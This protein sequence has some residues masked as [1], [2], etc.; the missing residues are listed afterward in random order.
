MKIQI[1][2]PLW[3]RLTQ[4]VVEKRPLNGCQSVISPG[5]EP[6]ETNGTDITKDVETRETRHCVLTECNLFRVI[7][8]W[9]TLY[10]CSLS[11]I[12]WFRF[13][14]LINC[15]YTICCSWQAA[16]RVHWDYLSCRHATTSPAVI[17]RL[18][19]TRALQPV[20]TCR[21][22]PYLHKPAII[23]MTSFSLWRHLRVS[24]LRLSQFPR[25]HYDVIRY[26]AGHAHRYGRTDTLPRLI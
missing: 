23:I 22:L 25:S 11:L 26:W 18:V 20:A 5:R 9:A 6:L 14:R 13:Y 2:L 16:V 3:C 12:Y 15:I 1:G 7:N 8:I 17:R 4:V 10:M 19:V 21:Q 24:R